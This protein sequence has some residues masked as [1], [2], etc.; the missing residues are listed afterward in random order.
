MHIQ[1][2]ARSLRAKAKKIDPSSCTTSFRLAVLGYRS[3]QFLAK[4]I[5]D[6][7]LIH[8]IQI[9]LYEADYNQ[10]EVEILNM[11]SALYA[12]N[13]QIVLIV[14]SLEKWKKQFYTTKA[15][16]KAHFYEDIASQQANHCKALTQRLSAQ[17]VLTNLEDFP[18]GIFGNF[19]NRT[20]DSFSNQVR[21][22]NVGLMDVAE[23]E[24]NVSILDVAAM[25]S[26]IGKAS[27][28]DESLNINADIPYT[29]DT[30]AKVAWEFANM[31]QVYGGKFRK[32]LILDLDNTLWG[33][34]IGDDG[35]AGIELGTLGI[36]KAFTALQLWIKQLKERG[37]ILA[38]CSKNEESI[39][40]EV[41]Q[42]HPDMV[43]QLEDIAVFVA[44]WSNKADNIRHI[45]KVLNIGFDTMVFIDDN[46]AEREL[47]RNMIPEVLVPELPVDPA[48]YVSFLSNLNLFE[49]TSYSTHDQARTR[50]YQEEAQRQ[51]VAQAFTDISDFLKGLEMKAS[52]VPFQSVNIP[53]IAQLSQRSNQ[54]NL[55]TIRYTEFDVQQILQDDEFLSYEVSLEDRIGKYGLVSIVVLKATA[56]RTLFIENWLM[57]CRV[58]KR[59][60]EQLLMNHLVKD[61]LELGYE[62]IIGEYIPTAKNK[63]V[64]D[65]YE[66]L[67]FTQNESG[68]WELILS[69]FTPLPHFISKA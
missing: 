26:A 59:G 3:T 49:T 61:A 57:S 28:L 24:S 56:N 40:K 38:I 37:I 67:G 4:F 21:R 65:H 17:I 64:E 29:L 44:N 68:K 48:Q 25:A 32:C 16:K 35:L 8:G 47:V 30:E 20:K 13:P 15:S 69:N 66:S 22:I 55:R 43:L 53:R 62:R 45:Q 46:P 23:A 27:F 1:L 36:G 2:T 34:I 31:L 51:S 9:E 6:A 18:D 50:Q 58:L 7:A 63:L 39:A 19:S 14:N 60:V 33:G 12:F 42:K 5:L 11:D 52:I 54:F 10:L 41:F